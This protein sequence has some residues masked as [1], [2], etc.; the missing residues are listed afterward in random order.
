[1]ANDFDSNI[2]RQLIRVFLEKFESMRVLSKNVDTQLLAGK[3]NPSTGDTVDFKRPTDYTTFRNPTGDL[4][5]HTPDDIITGKASGIVQDYFTV[6][7]NYD[8]ADEAIK[9]DQLD[10]LLA[11]MATRVVTDLELDF[12]DFMMINSG[13][14]AGDYG[15]AAD[16]W[17]DIADAGAVMKANGVPADEEWFY[18]V[19]P[20]TQAA[21]SE[22][23]RS[24]GSGGTSGEL[25][26]QAHKNATL[27]DNFGG[28]KVMTATTLASYTSATTGDL[29]GA[30]NGAPDVTYATAKDTMTQV[31][32]VDSF[33]SFAGSIPAGTVIE[34]TGVNRLN[35][36][37]RQPI[38]DGAGANVVWTAVVVVDSANFSSGAGSLTV[39]GPG[40]FEA[41]GAHNSTDVA[42]GA[43]NVVTILS[44]DNTLFQPNL[45][46]H[47]QAFSIGSV[48]IK[49]LHSTDTFG[50]TEDGLQF[51]VSKGSNF[52]TNVQQVR[53]DFRPA[54]A[55]LN[56]FF[57]GQGW[58]T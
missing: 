48:P 21:L 47:K 16:A 49:R 19:N 15:T 14:L 13:L 56:P 27:S 22:I 58:G 34:I 38:I 31:L 2:T 45:F 53:I 41:A 39:S 51:R 9:M 8:E 40:I 7:V 52:T 54:Y 25:V 42:I 12:A 50:E 37:T 6:L 29:V 4:T 44:A 36:S 32:A 17:A 43:A 57:S 20:F 28:L 10:E 3:F 23:Q 5:A 55:V 18:T 26:S 33:G 11:P 24:L 30:M 46:W 35:Q 1:M